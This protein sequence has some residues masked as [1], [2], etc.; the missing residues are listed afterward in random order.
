MGVFDDSI[1]RSYIVPLQVIH[2][3]IFFF[4][5]WQR[6]APAI[7]SMCSGFCALSVQLL[8]SHIFN[9]PPASGEEVHMLVGHCFFL[10]GDPLHKALGGNLSYR[11]QSSRLC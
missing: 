8:S 4:R 11:C 10:E 1:D 5:S 7:A 2:I 9:S 6:L 3:V